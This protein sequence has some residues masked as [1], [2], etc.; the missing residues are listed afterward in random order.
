MKKKSKLLDCFRSASC[1]ISAWAEDN[2]EKLAMLT[3]ATAAAFGIAT[4]VKAC[5]T[6]KFTP[7]FAKEPTTEQTV[8][9]NEK[10][11]DANENAVE[12]VK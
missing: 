2:T 12:L 6:G 5:K 11:T 4:G 3:L 7:L 8:D 9:A 10:T 1:K